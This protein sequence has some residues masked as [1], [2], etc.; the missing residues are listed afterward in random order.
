MASSIKQADDELYDNS[1]SKEEDLRRSQN[2][3]LAPMT[4]DSA[5]LSHVSQNLANMHQ[6]R[7]SR[8]I[9]HLAN[10]KIKGDQEGR[11]THEATPLTGRLTL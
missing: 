5:E 9:S 4:T 1:E 11:I 7:H 2:H 8:D 6:M 3:H 10:T